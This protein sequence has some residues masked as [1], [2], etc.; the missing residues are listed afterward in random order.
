[1]KNIRKL[2]ALLLLCPAI[3]TLSAQEEGCTIRKSFRVK[4]GTWLKVNGKYGDISIISSPSDS[5]T[6]CATV[7]IDQDNGELMRKSM[8]LILLNPEKKGDTVAVSTIIDERFFSSQYRSGRR[9]FSIS[10]AI[11]IPETTNLSLVNTFGD[12]IIDET[13]GIVNVS[14]SH[15]E[16][17]GTVFNRGNIRPV[18]QL[19]LEHARA[20][21]GE[22]NWMII[23]AK[24][25]QS[26]TIKKARALVLTTEFSGFSL[27]EAGSVVCKSRSD[28]YRIG[29]INN[30]I[31]ESTYSAFNI[32]TLVSRMQS[33]T[34][35]GTVGIK[36]LMKGFTLLELTGT[37]TP[38]DITTQKDNSFK[39]DISLINTPFEFDLEANPAVK[40]STTGTVTSLSGIAGKNMETASELRLKLE[41][42]LLRIK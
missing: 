23:N 28:N 22:V 11:K 19:N 2:T 8:A 9:S 24:H 16:L 21:I 3:M 33:V 5:I 17:N 29:S 1:M 25:C 7:K 37:H 38:V 13:S 35:Y 31:S 39:C 27:D 12:I 15:G 10:Y 40:K 30:L 41:R 14:L 42:G 34:I 6:I 32:G 36:E 4:E 20:N 18:S 26:V